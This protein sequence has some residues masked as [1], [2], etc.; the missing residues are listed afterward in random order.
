MYMYT[1]IFVRSVNRFRL[2]PLERSD[3]IVPLTECLRQHAETLTVYT[4]T[5]TIH[6]TRKNSGTLDMLLDRRTQLLVYGKK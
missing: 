6:M 3:V 2:R 5:C 1:Y 4:F